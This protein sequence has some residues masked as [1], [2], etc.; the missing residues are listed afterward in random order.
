MRIVNVVG[1]AKLGAGPVMTIDRIG[2][3]LVARLGPR[4]D[5]FHE[6]ESTAFEQEL[7]QAV[8]DCPARRIVLDLSQT[9]YFSSAT[10]E[11]L[12]RI[13][14]KME[15]NGD[16]RMAIASANPF[17]REIVTTARLDDLWPLYPDVDAAVAALKS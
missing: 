4:Y 8:D 1:V 3:V 12:F 2:E 9:E 17:C 11:T 6:T 13:W 7:S 16:A 14:K 15:S 5:A 10:I